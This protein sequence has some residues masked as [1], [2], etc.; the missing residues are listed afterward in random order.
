MNEEISQPVQ[1]LGMR[2]FLKRHSTLMTGNEVIL[3]L[4]TSVDICFLILKGKV[5]VMSMVFN[6][7]CI[8]LEPSAEFNDLISPAPAP[9]SSP[10]D[11]IRI[12]YFNMGIFKSPLPSQ[13][14]SPPG[15]SIIQSCRDL[16]SLIFSPT[17]DYKEHLIILDWGRNKLKISYHW[18]SSCEE[19][20]ILKDINSP[21]EDIIIPRSQNVTAIHNRFSK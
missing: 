13:L 14:P 8:R 3:V 20:N 17:H 11:W 10:N 5:W 4:P 12:W 2:V 21:W 1:K 7:S 15:N 18:G 6:S 9:H 16:P 19:A